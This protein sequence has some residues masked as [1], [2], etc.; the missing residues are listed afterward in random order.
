MESRLLL[1]LPIMLVRLLDW[2]GGGFG[3]G[4]NIFTQPGGGLRELKGGQNKLSF[5]PVTSGWEAVGDVEGVEGSGVKSTSLPLVLGVGWGSRLHADSR[6]QSA[7]S[8]TPS[9]TDAGH[10]NSCR[11]MGLQAPVLTL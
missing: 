1:I 4:S 8:G 5:E 11:T 3:L 6:S 10:T 9:D 7:S 2:G